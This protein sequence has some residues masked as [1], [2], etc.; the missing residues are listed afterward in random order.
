VNCL[1][2]ALRLIDYFMNNIVI[3]S[4]IDILTRCILSE[5]GTFKR[6]FQI[7]FEDIQITTVCINEI[8]FTIL[9]FFLFCVIQV[10]TIESN[11]FEKCFNEEMVNQ[12]H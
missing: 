2:C 9:S 11:L 3:S 8:L 10:F 5:R 1:D 7:Q 4:E 6:Y 12:K